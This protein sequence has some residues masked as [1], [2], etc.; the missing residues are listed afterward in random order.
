MSPLRLPIPPLRPIKPWSIPEV[1]VGIEG[2]AEGV[3]WQGLVAEALVS[4]V[5]QGVGG[6]SL[7][8]ASA[9]HGV[10]ARSVSHGP[11]S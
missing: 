11:I 5:R 10:F 9:R 8:A 2:M 6:Q 7:A 4:E 3:R 1:G